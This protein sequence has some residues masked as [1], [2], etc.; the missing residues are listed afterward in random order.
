MRFYF[1]NYILLFLILNIAPSFISGQVL[2][3]SLYKDMGVSISPSTM[4]L[5]IKPGESITRDIRLKNDTENSYEF[6]IGFQDFQMSTAGKASMSFTPDKDA[7]EE[8]N[9]KDF[10]YGLSRHIIVTPNAFTLKPG[11]EIKLKVMVD[12]PDEEENYVAKWGIIT[13]DQIYEREPLDPGDQPNR[14]AMGIVPTFG[15]GVFVYQNPPN[16]KI[17]QLDIDAFRYEKNENGNRVLMSVKNVGDGIT[18]CISYLELMNMKTGVQQK[19]QNKTFT[20]LPQYHRIFNYEM[21]KDL[22][23][24]KYSAVGV[25]DY[26]HKEEIIAAELEFDI[27]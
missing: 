1:T 20:I 4:H 21:P 5:N 16:V 7:D 12:I 9:G 2:S 23:P 25:V 22:P 8:V 19:L 18:Y 11:E 6:V 3:D 24:G 13:I 17:N 26:G 10:K 15:F 27:E 14:L